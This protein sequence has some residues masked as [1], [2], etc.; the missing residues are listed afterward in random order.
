[1]SDQ[2]PPQEGGGFSPRPVRRVGAPPPARGGTP[3]AGGPSR[4]PLPQPPPPAPDRPSDGG[5][6]GRGLGLWIVALLAIL[7]GA[8]I[9]VLFVEPGLIERADEPAQDGS[10]AVAEQLPAAHEASLRRQLPAVPNVL[11]GVSPIFDLRTPRGEAG[12][13]ELTIRLTTP[14]QDARNLGAYSWDGSAWQRLSAAD[15]SSDGVSARVTL[16]EA[17]DNIAILRRL[18]F[19]DVVTG[20]VPRGHEPSADLVGSLTVVHLEGWTPGRDGSLLGGVDPVPPSITQSV[21]PVVWAAPDQSD[22]VNDI[23]ASDTLRQQHIGNI[24]FSIQTGR[25]DGVDI[26]YRNVSPALRAQFTSFIRELADQLHREGRG[27]SVHIP[28]TAAGDVGEGAYDLALLAAAADFIVL[29]PPLDLRSY[30]DAIAASL[31]VILEQVEPEQILL[32]LRSSSIVQSAAGVSEISQRDALGRASQLSIRE[33]GPYQAGSRVTLQGE[34]VMLDN[35]ST[36][37]R[38]DASHQIVT[39]TYPDQTGSAVT[40]WVENRFSASFKLQ[41][42]E[43]YE[44]GGVYLSNATADRAHA[45][46]WPAVSAFFESGRPDLRLPNSALFRPEFSVSGGSLSGAPGTGWQLWELPGEAG[47]YEAQLVIGDGDVRVGHVITVP[48]VP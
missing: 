12:P 33:P 45:N 29:E 32:A 35:A 8:V 37:L 40:I 2:T 34:S 19:R 28:L 3:F 24:Q 6:Q 42:V 14:T 48:V 21:W 7:L 36:G 4:Q 25:Y 11:G 26:D 38:W 5:G 31:P 17:P 22:I 13:F 1:M 15:L 18:Q 16:D 46:L 23:L 27:L 9:V 43:R 20:R 44:L 39:F 41:T 47:D 10:A 30:Q